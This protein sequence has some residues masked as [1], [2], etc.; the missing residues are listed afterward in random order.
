MVE[1]KKGE[2]LRGKGI[3]DFV[4]LSNG[5]YVIKTEDGKSANDFKVRA[6]FSLNP[7]HFLTPKHAHFAIDLYGKICANRQ[8]AREVFNAIIELWNNIPIEKLL[9]KYSAKTQNLPGY[10]LEYILYC[11]KWILEQEDINFNG[12]PERKQ[13]QLDEICKNQNVA[14]PKGRIGSQ[15]AISLLCDVAGGT[16]PV[17][18]MIKSNLDVMPRKRMFRP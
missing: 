2:K 18:A 3:I 6:V 4:R 7:L 11:L 14:V 5:W 10:S 1:I 17:E 16:H 13:K 12:R 8:Q 9:S 15:L